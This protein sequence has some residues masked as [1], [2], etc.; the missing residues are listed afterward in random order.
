MI[1]HE[2]ARR[3]G[4]SVQGIIDYPDRTVAVVRVRDSLMLAVAQPRAR[5]GAVTSFEAVDWPDI[6]R[7][8]IK[9]WK[10]ET[11]GEALFHYWD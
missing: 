2:A 6:N 3:T 5:E 8:D 7:A 10:P 1:C 9:Y 4:G 11:V